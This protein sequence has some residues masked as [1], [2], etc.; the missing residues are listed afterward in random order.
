[1]GYLIQ[2]TR[3]DY[4]YQNPTIYP[5]LN[6]LHA[7]LILLTDLPDQEAQRFEGYSQG[8]VFPNSV[9]VPGARTFR[10]DLGAGIE[11]PS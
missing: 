11:E 10:G 2:S 3:A 8:D 4:V 9:V 5:R 7:P 6:D 1:M